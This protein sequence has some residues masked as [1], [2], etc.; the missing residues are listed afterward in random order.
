M[1]PVEASGRA[2]L[3]RNANPGCAGQGESAFRGFA[4]GR[5]PTGRV[6]GPGMG[7]EGEKV[8]GEFV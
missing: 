6:E 5:R 1:R 3:G 7:D 8:L 4:L 2:I